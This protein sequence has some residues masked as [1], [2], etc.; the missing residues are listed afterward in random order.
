MRARVWVGSV[1][2]KCCLPNP[3][4]SNRQAKQQ[5]G[6]PVS[7][8]QRL[9]YATQPSSPERDLARCIHKLSVEERGVHA[10]SASECHRGLGNSHAS[11]FCILKRAEAP[12]SN[13]HR[14]LRDAQDLAGRRRIRFELSPP[15]GITPR[16]PEKLIRTCGRNH[17]RV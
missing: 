12:R 10:A 7:S 4:A 13:A 2:V 8:P 17:D 16:I 11:A 9:G 14:Q 1:W 5:A 15:T 6:L 3:R